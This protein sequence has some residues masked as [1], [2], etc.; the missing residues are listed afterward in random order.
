MTNKDTNWMFRKI[1]HFLEK[2]LTLAEKERFKDMDGGD[3]AH[4]L[5]MVY[6][7]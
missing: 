7:A 6:G 2:E 3:F 4:A 1:L 5:M